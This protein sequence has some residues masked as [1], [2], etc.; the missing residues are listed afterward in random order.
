MADL[1]VLITGGAG[2]IGS[3]VIRH[4]IHETHYQVLNLDKLTYAG[5]LESLKSV[6]GSDRYDF[7]QA[8]ICNYLQLSEAFKKHRP[9]AVMH[10]A[11]ESHVDRS[12]DDPGDFIQTNIVGT[13]NLLE[14]ARERACGAV[15]LFRCGAR[16]RCGAR[17]RLRA[18]RLLRARA[19]GEDGR[20]RG[21]ALH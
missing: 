13:Y 20:E 1:K 11:A 18:R 14:A 9:N 3:A 5:N 19:R 8:D 21:S 15:R 6:D 7:V 2:F 12:I 4:L 16:L 17:A 10:L